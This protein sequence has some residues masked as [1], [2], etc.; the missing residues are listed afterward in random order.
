MSRV[1]R[2]MR[3]RGWF[4]VVVPVVVAAF[5]GL[6]GCAPPF[7][8]PLTAS[9]VAQ[10]DS[11][12]ALI[13]YLAQR[14]ASPAVCDTRSAGAHVSRFDWNRSEALVHGLVHG[15]WHLG[16]ARPEG[17]GGAREVEHV[18]EHAVDA[19][20]LA[21]H[22]LEEIALLEDA[23]AKRWAEPEHVGEYAKAQNEHADLEDSLSEALYAE[24]KDSWWR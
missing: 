12:A 2:A 16:F 4:V 11:G 15:S 10:L 17:H 9:D 23:P 7:P 22:A 19:L 5:L 3:W 24:L 20:G 14:D 8:R 6:G 18:A 13:T 1:L 21:L